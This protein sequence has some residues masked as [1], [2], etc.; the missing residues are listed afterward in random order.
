V[1][2][3]E[4]GISVYADCQSD[5]VVRSDSGDAGFGSRSDTGSVSLSDL[6]KSPLS[7]RRLRILVI[8]VIS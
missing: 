3:V 8:N 4:Y 7:P 1:A 5:N 2:N 6:K